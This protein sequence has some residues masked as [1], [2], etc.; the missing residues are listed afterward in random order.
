MV[1]VP[2]KNGSVRICTDLTHLNRQIERPIYPTPTP[3]DVVKSI[4]PQASI[5]STLDALSGYWQMPLSSAASDLT[6][7]ITPRGKFRYLR[8]PMG[9]AATGDAY[10]FRGD[11]ALQGLPN[12][13]KI[14]DDILIYSENLED[15]IKHVRSVLERCQKFGITLNAEKCVWG[16]SAVQYAG[17]IICPGSHSPNPLRIKAIQNFPIPSN[18]T[19]L[20]SFTGLVNQLCAFSPTIAQNSSPLR[21]LLKSNTKFKWTQDHTVAFDRVKALLISPLMLAKFDSS[22]DTIL[23][24]DASRHGFVFVLV[25]RSPSRITHLQL[26]QCG[27]RFLQEAEK[28][29]AMIELEALAMIW[30]VTKCRLFL[31]GYSFTIVTDHKRWFPFSMENPCKT[32]GM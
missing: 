14:V 23:Y 8:S 31:A 6:T 27:S 22:L 12:V 11:L 32:S 19:E 9:Y 20:R 4:P 17:D 28:R 1:I 29:Y 16:S 13:S 18:L 21:D 7:F 15:H 25:Q 3:Q 30:A 10:S 26:M 5:F 24:T 2:K